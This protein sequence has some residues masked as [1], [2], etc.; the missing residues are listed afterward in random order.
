VTDEWDG[1]RRSVWRGETDCHGTG[2]GLAWR[3]RL[4]TVCVRTLGGG[5]ERESEREREREKEKESRMRRARTH[6]HIRTC[7]LVQR[8]CLCHSLLSFSFEHRVEMKTA[9]LR[10][11]F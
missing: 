3:Q 5:R 2:H 7:R 4:V 10:L 9:F 8:A 1:A 11:L 6:D